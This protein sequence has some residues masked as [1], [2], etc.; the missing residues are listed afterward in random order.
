LPW[1]IIARAFSAQMPG[2]RRFAAG[3][4]NDRRDGGYQRVTACPAAKRQP[5]R[6]WLSGFSGITFGV[7]SP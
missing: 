1:A 7:F 5:V 3:S 6:N 4:Q 2:R